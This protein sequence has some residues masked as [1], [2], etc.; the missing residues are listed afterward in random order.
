M[1]IPLHPQPHRPGSFLESFNIQRF[2]SLNHIFSAL[3]VN[4]S[5][6][7]CKLLPRILGFLG[8][9]CLVASS[10]AGDPLVSLLDL[11]DVEYLR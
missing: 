10:P 3:C 9:D 6:L 5:A 11:L 4:I 8:P 1:Y 2:H 7:K